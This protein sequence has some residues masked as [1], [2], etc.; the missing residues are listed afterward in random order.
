MKYVITTIFI[1]LILFWCPLQTLRWIRAC[2]NCY[3]LYNIKP[4]LWYCMYL[5]EY[6]TTSP[7][8]RD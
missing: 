2:Y 7:G 8:F 6:I 1:F 4:L 3:A 5:A